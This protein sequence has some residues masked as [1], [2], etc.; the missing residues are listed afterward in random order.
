MSGILGDVGGFLK[1]TA[2]G[3]WDG[4][5]GMVQGVGGLAH[6]GYKLATDGQY[7]KQAWDS[8]VKDAKAAGDFAGTAVTDPGKAADEVGHAASGAWHSVQ[9]AYDEA[10]AHGQGSAFIGKMF[11]QGAILV[12]TSFVPGGAEADAAGALGD[13]G[14]MAEIA[15]YAGKTADVGK[16]TDTAALAGKAAD[17]GK[18]SDAGKAAEED[19]LRGPVVFKAPPGATQEEIAQVHAYVDGSNEALK[20]GK[21]SPTGRVSTAGDLRTDASLAAATERARAAAEGVPYTGHVGHVPD[22]TWTGQAQPYKWLDLTPRVNAS[23]GGQAAHYP[24][25]Y[26]PTEFTVGGP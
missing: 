12:G 6:D 2:E 9:T 16:A 18:V 7:R 14:R 5:K 20:A 15:G 3:A 22:T 10:S 26:K 4:A 23:L 8:A 13:A 21:L 19:P 24:I 11:G 25:G 17:A 1:G